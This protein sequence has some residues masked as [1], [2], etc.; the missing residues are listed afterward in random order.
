MYKM[1]SSGNAGR[2]HQNSS[3]VPCADWA[4]KTGFLARNARLSELLALWGVSF[5]PPGDSGAQPLKGSA[6]LCANFAWF[7]VF[8]YPALAKSLFEPSQIPNEMRVHCTARPDFPLQLAFPAV[9]AY[10]SRLAFHAVATSAGEKYRPSELGL[11]SFKLFF[12]DMLVS[13]IIHGSQ[14]LCRHVAWRLRD[15]G[16]LL[17][18]LQFR[19]GAHV[20]V[21]QLLADE[22]AVGPVSETWRECGLETSV[23]NGILKNLFVAVGS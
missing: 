5:R 20:A 6:S 12:E 15:K 11:A 2:N 19:A 3:S 16:I 1:A 14:E 13:Q 17:N 18:S 23:I 7:T 10:Q 9:E 22:T 4:A 8:Q 21:S